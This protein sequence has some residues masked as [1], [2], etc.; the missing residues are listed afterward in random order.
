MVLRNFLYMSYLR[1][2]APEGKGDV[3]IVSFLSP[4]ILHAFSK[5]DLELANNSSISSLLPR[6]SATG[7]AGGE[8]EAGSEL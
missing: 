7:A 8:A 1:K 5:T 3:K 2:D 4:T 6:A